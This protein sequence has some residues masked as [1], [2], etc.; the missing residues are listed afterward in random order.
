MKSLFY[1]LLI[2]A[3]FA[4]I[5]DT[6]QDGEGAEDG[7]IQ[8]GDGVTGLETLGTDADLETLFKPDENDESLNESDAASSTGGDVT[9][10]PTSD[11]NGNIV[12][13]G[14]VDPELSLAEKLENGFMHQ[15]VQPEFIRNLQVDVAS[16]M[17]RYPSSAEL[18]E[19]FSNDDRL[20]VFDKSQPDAEGNPKEFMITVDGVHTG[21]WCFLTIVMHGDHEYDIHKREFFFPCIKMVESEWNTLFFRELKPDCIK[22]QIV[23]PKPVIVRKCHWFYKKTKETYNFSVREMGPVDGADL[24]ECYVESVKK[25]VVQPR[26][27]ILCVEGSIVDNEYQH[28]TREEYDQ[29]KANHTDNK[30]G[31]FTG[32]QVEDEKKVIQAE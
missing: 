2:S 12:D 18:F 16:L 15:T 9:F 23:E 24:L 6:S 22:P 5:Q 32:E 20:K 10:G 14:T 19:E 26:V 17:R 21:E 28:L 3:A 11:D 30:D 25:M 4:Q 7:T 29:I 31:S 1:L 8:V 27:D 13:E